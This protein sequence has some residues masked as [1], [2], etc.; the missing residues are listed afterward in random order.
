M[1]RFA[2]VS[3]AGALDYAWSTAKH[4]NVF[5]TEGIY[6]GEVIAEEYADILEQ[7][8]RELIDAGVDALTLDKTLLVEGEAADARA[9]GDAIRAVDEK[10]NSAIKEV[11]E[12]SKAVSDVENAVFEITIVGETVESI[13]KFNPNTVSKEVLGTTEK[14]VSEVI[15]CE[16]GD[17]LMMYKKCTNTAGEETA[18]QE[19]FGI[20]LVDASGT[21]VLVNLNQWATYTVA[22]R[23]DMPNLVGVRVIPRWLEPVE[24]YGTEDLKNVMLTINRERDYVFIPWVESGE[25][26]KEKVNLIEKNREELQEQIDELAR[27]VIEV[28]TAEEITAFESVL[29]SNKN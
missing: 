18:S 14:F 27:Q 23:A 7:W 9:A 16:V 2:C 12:Q 1:I 4:N 25:P 24:N 19:T 10:A 5:V 28:P 6:N 22:S 26:V 21:E 13:N 3:E 11:R 17:V 20:K 29:Y 8:K 15:P